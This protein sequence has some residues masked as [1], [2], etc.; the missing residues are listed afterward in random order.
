MGNDTEMRGTGACFVHAKGY[1][2][3]VTFN[4]SVIEIKRNRFATMLYGFSTTVV[5]I[6][7]VVDLSL[8]KATMFINGLFCL[9]VRTID[10]DTPLIA[11]VPDSRMSPYC[12]VYTNW[13]RDRFRRLYEAI[14]AALPDE[15]LPI[16]YDQTPETLYMRLLERKAEDKA[17]RAKSGR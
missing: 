16:A 3:E 4:G 12:A 7:S 11:D 1:G 17:K 9:S 10:G 5:P 6:G 8:G 13:Q 14:G 2:Y 15:A